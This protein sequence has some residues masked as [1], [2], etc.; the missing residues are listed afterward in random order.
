[1]TTA[2]HYVPVAPEG[3][4]LAQ[5]LAAGTSIAA[6]V[7]MLTVGALS[8][9]EGIAAVV[10]DDLFMLGG[11]YIYQMDIT[12]W[13]WIHIGIGAALILA[14][15]GLITGSI[16]GRLMAIG[17]AALCIVANF[18]WLPHYPWWSTVIIALS[19]VAIWAI[20]TWRTPT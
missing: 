14:A 13:G 4:P 11:A 19:V 9:L 12:T 18:L 7:L 1:M 6:A 20:A 16:W 17:F 10:R 8:L 3:P 5:G 2:P 15:V